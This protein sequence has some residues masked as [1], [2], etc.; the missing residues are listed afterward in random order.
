M[1]IV[2]Q[3]LDMRTATPYADAGRS[4]HAVDG[5][6]I[7]NFE[8]LNFDVARIV[9][10]DHCAVAYIRSK[11]APIQNRQLSRLTPKGDVPFLVPR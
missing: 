7:S 6:V 4:A 10:H 1:D 8:A 9:K 2:V 3:Y 5:L 11:A